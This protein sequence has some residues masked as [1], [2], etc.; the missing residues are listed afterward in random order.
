MGK[1]LEH[2]KSGRYLIKWLTFL[3]IFLIIGGTFAFG[4]TMSLAMHFGKGSIDPVWM[5][6]MIPFMCIIATPINIF[7]SKLM[8]RHLD[9]L[10]VSMKAVANGVKG[11]YIP[12]ADAKAFADLYNDFNIM[13]AEIESVQMLRT[14]MIDGLSHELKTPVASI[15]GFAKLLLEENLSAEKHDNYVKIIIKESERLASLAKNSLLLSK[16]DSQE[17]VTEKQCYNL[18]EQIKDCVISLENEWESKNIDLSAD[19]SEMNYM[20]NF[21]LM[22]SLWLNLINNAIKFTPDN[23][24]INISLSED[25]KSIVFKISDSGVGMSQKVIDHIFERYYQGDVSHASNGHGLGLSIALRIAR[26][27]GGNITVESIEGKGSVFTVILPKNENSCAA[28]S[29]NS[30]S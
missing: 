3:S 24:A 12:T 13:T 9:T 20:G 11:V 14:E 15:N 23:G 25:E 27:C 5:V 6:G 21:T 29:C 17:I 22:E 7:I 18:T 28:K 26:L 19:L 1:K 2:S 16:I 10:S 4:L 8:Y 30:E